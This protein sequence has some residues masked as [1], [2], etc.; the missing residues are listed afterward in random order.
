M[1]PT[2]TLHPLYISDDFF[3]CRTIHE[4]LGRLHSRNLQ[5]S[6]QLVSVSQI[7]SLIDC[8][9]QQLISAKVGKAV[10]DMMVEG[11]S[12]LAVDIVDERGWRQMDDLTQ[13]EQWC[14]AL[15]E[16]Y[17]EKAK[18]VR[19]GNIGVLGFFV[20][21]V[22]K[23]SKGRANPVALN[24]LLRQKIGLRKYHSSSTRCK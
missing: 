16:R 6:P 10:L 5:F 15:I 4:L 8:V 1:Q 13:L 19:E 14:D 17:P 20:G 24:N 12:R 21:Q 23:Q 9:D 3:F 18:V 2:M 11:D 22:M 7:G